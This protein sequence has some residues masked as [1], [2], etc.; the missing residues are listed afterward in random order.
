MWRRGLALLS[1]HGKKLFDVARTQ[2]NYGYG[3]RYTRKMWIRN[4]HGE[5]SFWTLTRIIVRKQGARL[6]AY[7][8]FTWRGVT[9]EK[10][11]EI[12]GAHKREW[13]LFSPRGAGLDAV[14]ARPRNMD[15][16]QV[17]KRASSDQTPPPPAS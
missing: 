9:D 6:K 5:D 1:P 3:Q 10:E 16:E 17:P 14:D 15:A 4:G 2:L 7:G 13:T 11:R 8:R 12:R